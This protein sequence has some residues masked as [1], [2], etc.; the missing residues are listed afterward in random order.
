MTARIFVNIAAYR[1]EDVPNTLES[2]FATAKGSV[3][4]GVVNQNDG[5]LDWSPDDKRVDV[6]NIDHREAWGVGW[7]RSLA[8]GF[9]FDEPYVL[10]IDAHMRFAPGWDDALIADIERIGSKRTILTQGA[11][12]PKHLG[13]GLQQFIHSRYWSGW[14]LHGDYGI[15]PTTG[16]PSITRG[17]CYGCMIFAPAL[18]RFEVPHD[19]TISFYT[20]EESLAIRSWTRGWDIWT[21]SEGVIGHMER[22]ENMHRKFSDDPGFTSNL[23]KLTDERMLRIRQG[24]YFGIYGPGD[25]RSTAD[26][27]KT[28]DINP[29]TPKTLDEYF[30]SVDFRPGT[31]IADAKIPGQFT[32]PNPWTPYREC[33]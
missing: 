32:V 18:W 10:Q 11:F 24:E 26:Y 30:S 3:R 21:P 9:Y 1:D 16:K 28:I 33:P 25:V 31:G 29:G 22:T 23:C 15:G 4:A 27:W 13:Q 2:M 12:D 8:D 6:V 5:P 19:P 17:W 14:L 7:A 20:E